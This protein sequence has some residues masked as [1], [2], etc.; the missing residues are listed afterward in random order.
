[1]NQQLS[2][3]EKLQ[4]VFNMEETKKKILG[5]VHPKDGN[6]LAGRRIFHW[7]WHNFGGR[8]RSSDVC[9]SSDRV[10]FLN[11][12]NELTSTSL[13]GINTERFEIMTIDEFENKYPFVIGNVAYVKDT[14]YFGV[15]TKMYWD[16]SKHTVM[17]KLSNGDIHVDIPRKN[18]VEI[19]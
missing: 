9:N 16:E 3:M 7:L 6:H 17:Y 19:C 11:D 5:L 14:P 4:Y 18:L 12:C 8:P 1:M 15:I 10:Y 2:L 13:E